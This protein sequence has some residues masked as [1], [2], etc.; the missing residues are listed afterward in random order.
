MDIIT[1]YRPLFEK[2]DNIRYVLISGGR[3][4]GK[5]HTAS[6]YILQRLMN[7]E[8]TRGAFM[9]QTYGTIES[10]IY[11]EIL[12]RI[13]EEKLQNKVK[14]TKKPYSFRYRK[15]SFVGLSF[16]ASSGSQTAKLKSIS[17]F[18][19]IVIEEAEEIEEHD[20]KKLTDSL[21]KVGVDI[22]VV[23]L[24][25]PPHAYHWINE[26]FF[27]LTPYPPNP[28]YFVASLKNIHK[29]SALYIHTTYEDN[30]MHI[31]K[32]TI[33]EYE[34]YKNDDPSHYYHMIRGLIPAVKTGLIFTDY[35]T[36]SL[37]EYESIDKT[38]YFGMDFGSNDP[39]TLQ[40]VKVDESHN[41]IY[42]KEYFYET[43]LTQA[44]I[45]AYLDELN[46]QGKIACDSSAKQMI[47]GLKENGYPVY[48]AYKRAG[49]ILSGI[50]KLQGYHLVICESSS[51]VLEEIKEY[52]WKQNKDKKSSDTPIDTFNH[53]FDAIRY[54]ILDI[55]EPYTTYQTTS[56]KKI[57]S[58]LTF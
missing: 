53:G 38:E 28:N 25:N 39:T 43:K 1:K 20:F 44:R 58:R 6:Q 42:I 18:N 7:N 12:D 21:R 29:E 2:P 35:S 24:F 22:T 47:E 49:S 40:G 13:N 34:Q 56:R 23:L 9:R 45:E 41:K 10:S 27:D 37:D 33:L 36:C 46:I 4:S 26:R 8:Y 54:A 48:S 57:M 52:S 17:G 19:I 5:S 3:G 15:N 30:K 55:S 11:Q 31:H 50:Q 51:G 32:Q 16:K 14:I